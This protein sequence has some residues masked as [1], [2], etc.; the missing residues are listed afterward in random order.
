M[1]SEARSGRGLAD[2][3]TGEGLGDGL[4][5]PTSRLAGGNPNS[6]DHWSLGQ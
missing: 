6:W 3:P 2:E 1:P 4:S 5:W